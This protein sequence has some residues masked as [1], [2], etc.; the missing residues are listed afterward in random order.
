MKRLLSLLLLVVLLMPTGVWAEEELTLDQ[1]LDLALANN[2]QIAAAAETANAA[3]AKWGQATAG[4]LPTLSLSASQGQNYSQPSTI[5]LP[6]SLGGG[7]FSTGPDEAGQVTS[8]SLTLT[9]PLFTGGKLIQGYSVAKISYQAV[10][11]QLRQAQDG[12]KFQVISAYYGLMK[13]RKNLELLDTAIDNLQRNRDQAEVFYQAGLIS[14]IDLLRVETELANSTVNRIQAENGV[15]LARLSFESLLGQPLEPGIELKE[16]PLLGVKPLTLTQEQSL[17]LAYENRPEWRA[18]MLG[19]EAAD[20]ALS[21]AY[22]NFLPSLAYTYSR[23]RNLADYSSTSGYDSNL[24]NWRSMFVASWNIF[25]G[26]S[27]A[28]QIKEARASY[29]AA[30]AQV[31]QI[32]DAIAL[33]VKSAYL[34]LVSSA[35]RIEAAQLAAELAAKTRKLAEVNYRANIISEQAYLDAHTADQSAQL[36][37]WSARYDYEI[38][39]AALNKAIGKAVI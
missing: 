36:N 27:T 25:D 33:E 18:Y 16:E 37:L 31:R 2:P 12:V 14:N 32:Q 23:G 28:N 24:E 15:K 4:F 26:F 11:E 20:K 39:R 17:K 1:C 35:D 5:V 34:S 9:Q 6:D 19:L 13:A 30:Q 21:V 3:R 29:C 10:Q 38:A 8:Y 22:S 7:T